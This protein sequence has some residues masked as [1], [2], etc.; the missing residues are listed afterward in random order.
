MFLKFV[1]IAAL[2][3]AGIFIIAFLEDKLVSAPRRRQLEE[4]AR[5]R[6]AGS[7]KQQ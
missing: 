4:K 7:K 5:E 6:L 3:T 2:I 1:G